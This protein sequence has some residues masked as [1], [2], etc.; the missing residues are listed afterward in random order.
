LLAKVKLVGNYVHESAPVSQTGRCIRAA[1]S[2]LPT[3]LVLED[4]NP[5]ERKWTPEGIKLEKK[6]GA[7][8]H[9]EIL[10]FSI[11]LDTHE[12]LANVS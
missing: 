1:R 3:N 9:H 10:V 11:L 6:E 8:S 12:P 2:V 5:I 7:L 4:D